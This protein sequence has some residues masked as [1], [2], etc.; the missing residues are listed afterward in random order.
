[1]ASP[2][3]PQPSPEPLNARFGWL[4]LSNRSSPVVGFVYF[5][6]PNRSGSN[7]FVSG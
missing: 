4:S 7:H 3:D 1:M 2:F 6:W 5:I